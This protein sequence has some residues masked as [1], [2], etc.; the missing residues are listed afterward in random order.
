MP[1]TDEEK[2]AV[3]DMLEKFKANF[4]DGRLTNIKQTWHN[5]SHKIFRP[6]FYQKRGDHHAALQKHAEENPKYYNG[7]VFAY[8]IVYPKSRNVRNYK[9]GNPLVGRDVLSITMGLSEVNENGKVR[10][11]A[12]MLDVWYTPDEILKYGLPTTKDIVTQ[13]HLLKLGMECDPFSGL[14]RT[15]YV[16]A[17]KAF[18]KKYNKKKTKK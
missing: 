17:T 7:N 18:L 9:Y 4:F 6:L 3:V 16:K 15:A 10:S 13:M 8:I 12:T 1:L 2:D 5:P 14:S 11:L